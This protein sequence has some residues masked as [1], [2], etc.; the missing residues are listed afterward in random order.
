M[1]KRI[2][3]RKL[4]FDHYPPICSYC[5]FGIPEV[6][7]VAHLDGNKE[8][9]QIENLAILCANCHKMHD[10]NLIPTEI[11]IRMR[12]QEKQVDWSKRMK[13]A[14]KK[15]AVRRRRRLAGKKAAATRKRRSGT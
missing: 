7:E 10:I 11:V 15:A 14:G 13:D 1:P 3:Y 9:N 2:D 12:G 8:N 6:L 5:G 4:A